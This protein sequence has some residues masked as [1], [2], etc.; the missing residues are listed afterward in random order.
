M[1]YNEEMEELADVIE[2]LVAGGDDENTSSIG[3]K[4]LNFLKKKLF[5]PEIE[6]IKLQ[7]DEKIG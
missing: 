5:D 1:D 6:L 4:N 7:M 2:E 3:I